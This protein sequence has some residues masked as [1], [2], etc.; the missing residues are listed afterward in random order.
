MR[1]AVRGLARAVLFVCLQ[2][3]RETMVNTSQN[4]VERRP[5][6]R[7]ALPPA[8]G[9]TAS[10]PAPTAQARDFPHVP[11]VPFT[12]RVPEHVAG[13]LTYLF[14]WVSGLVFLLVDRRPF[15][16]YHAAQSAVVIATLSG[17]LLVLGDFFL[18]ALLPG[19]GAASFLMVLRRIVELIWLASA[20]VLMLKAA[21]GDRYRVPY[22]A[23]YADRVSRAKQ[24]QPPTA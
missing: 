8:A 4:N 13:M 12:E 3:K 24:G 20:V 5:E 18:A 7:V 1:R 15:V 16:R 23:A 14:G 10:A 2:Q 6:S 21:A 19:A 17:I 22:V 11:S 9:T